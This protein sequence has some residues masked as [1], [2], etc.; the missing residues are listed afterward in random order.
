MKLFF[1]D[2]ETL[3]SV[4]ALFGED[5]VRVAE[6]LESVAEI[7]DIQI[8]DQ[9]EIRLNTVRKTLYR[10]YDHSL[11]GLRRTR[12]KETGWFVFH[13]RLQ[14]DQL[15]GFIFN[16]KRRVLEKLETRLRYEKSHEFYCCKTPGCKRFPFAEAFEL[17]FKCP[18]CNRPMVH[19]NNGHIIE[20][21]TR[22]I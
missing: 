3:R 10:L 1:S 2:K 19:V 17:L 9:T 4:V 13:W 7:T 14:P 11:V 21:L 15:E 20:V 12:D 22:K 8:V 6:V 5:A 16:Q 18:A